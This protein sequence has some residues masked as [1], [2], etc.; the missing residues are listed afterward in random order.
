MSEI[1]YKSPGDVF[2]KQLAEKFTGERTLIS[3][4]LRGLSVDFI[5]MEANQ[6]YANSLSVKE[7]Y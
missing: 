7:I 5:G 3:K 1:W 2:S 4:F 6:H